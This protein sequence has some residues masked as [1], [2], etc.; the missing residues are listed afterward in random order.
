M[1]YYTTDEV[2]EIFGVSRS[3]VVRWCKLGRMSH[4]N[5][6]RGKGHGI[7]IGE[8]S[9]EE[10]A[11]KSYKYGRIYLM[12]EYISEDKSTRVGYL[13]VVKKLFEG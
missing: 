5:Y 2:A 13:L 6:G 8:D 11:K 3:T 10:F 4:T 9:I 12:H 7:E 1:C